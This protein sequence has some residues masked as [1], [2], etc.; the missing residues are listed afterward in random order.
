LQRFRALVVRNNNTDVAGSKRAVTRIVNVAISGRNGHRGAN[1]DGFLKDKQV[2]KRISLFCRHSHLHHGTVFAPLHGSGR[3]PPP[4]PVRLDFVWLIRTVSLDD[5]TNLSGS[6]RPIARILL[7]LISVRKAYVVTHTKRDITDGRGTRRCRCAGLGAF[8]SVP[9]IPP[10]S[11]TILHKRRAVR[12]ID[13]PDFAH[14]T[15]V[16]WP[17]RGVAN[18]LPHSR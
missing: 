1:D 11:M 18:K 13:F 5:D 6:E 16:Q 17:V 8:E 2:T 15:G 12:N 4:L 14:V 3:V 10:C 7:V 9:S